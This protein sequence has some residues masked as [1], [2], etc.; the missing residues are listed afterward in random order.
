MHTE[1]SF[2]IKPKPVNIKILP[3]QFWLPVA[4][5]STV[6]LVEYLL[7][8]ILYRQVISWFSSNIEELLLDISLAKVILVKNANILPKTKLKC[9]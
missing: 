6:L 1:M 4:T 2:S 8:L 3:K 7:E 5:H 9:F